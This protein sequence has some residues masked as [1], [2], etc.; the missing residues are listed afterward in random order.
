M[1]FKEIKPFIRY[2]HYLNVNQSQ[3]YNTTVPLDARLFFVL[4]GEGKIKFDDSAIE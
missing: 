1:L 4:E 2:A 3:E